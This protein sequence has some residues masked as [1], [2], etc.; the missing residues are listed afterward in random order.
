MYV[1]DHKVVVVTEGKACFS[2]LLRKLVHLLHKQ[3]QNFMTNLKEGD[4]F[5]L[6]KIL[7]D[8]AKTDFDCARVT[9][10]TQTHALGSY[11]IEAVLQ[12]EPSN[13]RIVIKNIDSHYNGNTFNFHQTDIY[14]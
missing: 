12:E 7:K 1:I 10:I 9:K 14:C 8:A 5:R 13:E 4:V 11:L 6:N 3:P 2:K